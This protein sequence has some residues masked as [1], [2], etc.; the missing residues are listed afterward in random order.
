MKTAFIAISVC[1]VSVLNVR[2]Q[3]VPVNSLAAAGDTAEVGRTSVKAH[4]AAAPG[5]ASA[6]APAA[7][8]KAAPTV[9]RLKVAPTAFSSGPNGDLFLDA[10]APYPTF[11]A[12]LIAHT[13]APDIFAKLGTADA[14]SWLSIVDVNQLELMRVRA[15]GRVGIGTTRPSQPVSALEVSKGTDTTLTITGDGGAGMSFLNFAADAGPWTKSQ[16]GA[17]KYGGD[18]GYL[19]FSTLKGG[20]LTEEARIDQ[21]GK[22]GIGTATPLALLQVAGDLRLGT[23]GTNTDLRIFS[24]TGTFPVI[25]NGVSYDQINSITPVAGTVT[26]MIELI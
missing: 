17:G 23:N 11:G 25:V 15:D 13:D 2:A 18:G 8:S 14:S 6:P 4:E 24:E 10:R 1:L 16:I 9:M 19:T 3:T 20:T 26:G 21:N 5:V 7:T 22:M 12:Q